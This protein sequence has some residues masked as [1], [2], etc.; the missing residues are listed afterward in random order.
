MYYKLNLMR[1]AFIVYIKNKQMKFNVS[2]QK[3][4]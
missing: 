1:N 3:E 4:M 2:I